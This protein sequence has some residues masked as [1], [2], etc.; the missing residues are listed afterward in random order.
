MAESKGCIFASQICRPCGIAA[1][2]FGA[3]N[4]PPDCFLNAPHPLRVL[5]IKKQQAPKGTCC[6][7]AES[8]GFEPSNSFWLLHDFQSC[9]FDQLGQ[10]STVSRCFFRP[11]S[12]LIII[13]YFVKIKC[14]FKFC[15]KF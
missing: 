6:S 8:K 3:E 15:R 10:L 9:S 4:S 5:I 12:P 13:V 7:L 11:H 2:D 14:F 1:S